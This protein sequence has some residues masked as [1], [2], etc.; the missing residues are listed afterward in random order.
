MNQRTLLRARATLRLRLKGSVRDGKNA[1]SNDFDE[2]YRPGPVEPPSTGHRA[3]LG[4]RQMSPS[5]V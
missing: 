3:G 4:G 1:Y 2:G 5:E